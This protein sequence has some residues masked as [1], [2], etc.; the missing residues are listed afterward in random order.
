MI[1]VN[2][3]TPLSVDGATTSAAWHLGE[4][5]LESRKMVETNDEKYVKFRALAIIVAIIC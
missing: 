4:T 1:W 5:E 2:A 3:T